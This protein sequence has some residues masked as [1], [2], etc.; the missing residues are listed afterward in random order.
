MSISRLNANI[1]I[2]IYCLINRVNDWLAKIRTVFNKKSRVDATLRDA[3]SN[4]N[5]PQNIFYYYIRRTFDIS[6]GK[7][8]KSVKVMAN[9]AE[10]EK[11]E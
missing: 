5:A 2:N 8:N 1:I 10:V 9:K 3:D 7:P 4:E 6:P 11:G